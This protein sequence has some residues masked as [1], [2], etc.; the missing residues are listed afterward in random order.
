MAQTSLESIK[1]LSSAADAVELLL[2]ECAE[3][4][5]VCRRLVPSLLKCSAKE[6]ENLIDELCRR[7][8]ISPKACPYRGAIALGEKFCHSF[9]DAKWRE[10]A[11]MPTGPAIEG[12]ADK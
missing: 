6:A 2:L 4:G 5:A 11:L 8:I 9:D 12:K 1:N 10:L 3:Q 7:G